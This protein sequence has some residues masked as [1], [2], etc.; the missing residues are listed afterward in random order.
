MNELLQSLERE[1]LRLGLDAGGGLRCYGDAVKARAMLPAIRRHKPALLELLT[2][3]RPEPDTALEGEEKQEPLNLDAIA[4]EIAQ[5]HGVDPAQV[6]ALLDDGDVEAI[7]TGSDPGRVDAW[8]GFAGLLAKDARE[9]ARPRNEVMIRC[10]D[11]QHAERTHHP[12]IVRCGV[13]HQ[14]PGVTGWW[15]LDQHE[16]SDFWRAQE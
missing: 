13:G 8:R 16:C 15:S 11:C 10:A 1:G 5:A 14:A 2:G 3:K 12:V 6:L 7:T 4:A 9:P